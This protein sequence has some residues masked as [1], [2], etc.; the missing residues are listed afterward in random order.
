[1]FRHRD[2]RILHNR[3]VSANGYRSHFGHI[4]KVPRTDECTIIESTEKHRYLLPLTPEMKVFVEK[5]KKPYPKRAA[6]KDIVAPEVHSGEA[7]EAPT[8]ALQM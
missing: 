3:A 4:R 5:L 6:S 7:G 1:M 2:G 8:A